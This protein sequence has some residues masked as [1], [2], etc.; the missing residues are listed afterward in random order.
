MYITYRVLLSDVKAEIKNEVMQELRK[1]EPKPTN[2]GTTGKKDGGINPNV[3][4]KKCKEKGHIARYC[5]KKP[6]QQGGREEN[7]PTSPYEVKPKD[8]EAQVKAI[9]GT[10]CSWCNWC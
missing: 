1:V 3:I 9:N 10:Q 6:T 5:P 8:G 7:K 2:G 4:C